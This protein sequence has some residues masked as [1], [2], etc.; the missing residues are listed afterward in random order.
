[1]TTTFR[2]VGGWPMAGLALLVALAWVD[3]A[4]GQEDP[5]RLLSEGRRAYDAGDYERARE[6]LW[7]YL[8][9]TAQLTGPSRLPQAEALWYIALM[10]PDAAV[11]VNHYRTIVDEYPAASVADQALFRLAVFEL[12]SGD[13]ASARQRLD[14]LRRDYP[15]SRVQPEI[16]MWIG[17]AN[18][19]QGD[20]SKAIEAFIEGYTQVKN[21]DLPTELP[22]QQREALAAEYVYWLAAAYAQEGDLAT[23]RQ[24]YTL[25]T[26]DYPDSPHAA[27]A[28]E[29]LAGVGGGE[30]PAAG[31]VAVRTDRQEPEFDNPPLPPSGEIGAED[32][33]DPI[34][35]LDVVE[36]D[37]A[38]P[39]EEPPRPEPVVVEEPAIE[40]EPEVARTPAET[41]PAAEPDRGAPAV[42]VEEANKLPA[43][44]PAGDTWLQVGAFSS[45]SNAADLSKRLKADGFDTKVEVG[46]V[47][48]QGYYRVRVG[49]F[50]LPR[51]RD[52]LDEARGRLDRLGYPA[53]QMS[54]GE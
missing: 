18:L 48:G 11:A 30:R 16:P 32:E 27:D 1:M 10:E 36:R 28:R 24:Y 50:D 12:V 23:A 54:G 45:A 13:P 43:P 51:D 26:L 3:P 37:D 44:A 31:E 53:R 38:A 29:A 42:R 41:E 21:Q 49:P 15:F 4:R 52:R 33:D 39:R 34:A 17:R 22:A 46:I 5:A 9:A 47:D 6:T 2:R 8:D 35:G 7:A 20:E 19:A 40:A 25:L 14:R